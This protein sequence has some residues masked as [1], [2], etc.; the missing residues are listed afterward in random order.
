MNLEDILSFN[1]P[2]N[3]RNLD[4]LIEQI[5]IGSVVPYAGAG[6]SILFDGIYPSWNGFLESTFDMFITEDKKSVFDT[7]D[8]EE[9]AEFLY[10][11]IGKISFADH[12]L[13]TFAEKYIR[14]NVS[15]FVTKPVYLLPIIFN[16]G[17]IMT[18]NYDKV[19]ERVYNIHDEIFSVAHPGHYEVFNRS[20]RDQ[21]LLVYKIHGDI[22]EP[23]TSIILSKE[24]YD[25]AY[26]NEMLIQTL[27]QAFLSKEMLFLGCSLTKDKPIEFLCSI[28]SEGMRNFA[29][30]SCENENK[31]AKRL[32]LEN[33]FFTQA[34]LY[35]EGKHE[36][37]K[38]LLDHIA[39]LVNPAG[40]FKVFNSESGT[41]VEI[42]KISLSKEWFINQN[43]IQIRNL[44]D[45]Y[46]PELN[47][48][49][50]LS[51]V[52]DGLNRSASFFERLS[53][54]TDEFLIKLK[55]LDID[56]IS[57]FVDSICDI[58]SCFSLDQSQVFVDFEIIQK[59]EEIE[60]ILNAQIEDLYKELDYTIDVN[61]RSTLQNNIYEFNQAYNCLDEYITYINS[62][63]ITVLNNPFVLLYGEGG[64]GKSHIIADTVRNREEEGRESLLF[65]GQ[66]FREDSSPLSIMLRELEVEHSSDDFFDILNQRAKKNQSRIVIFIDA[67]NEGNGKAVWKEYL[68]GIVE[69]IKKYDWLGLVVSVRE[70]YMDN[71]FSD[72]QQLY[73]MFVNVKHQGFSTI[74]YKAIK[75]YFEYYNVQFNDI[76]FAEQEFRNPL[77]LRLLCEGFRDD[78]IKLSEISIM[79][80]YK[81]YLD[82]INRKISETCGYSRHFNIVEKVINEMVKFKL[83]SGR[84][85]NLIS[86]ECAYDITIEIERRYNI[87]KSLFD[88]LLSNGVLTQNRR[89]DNLDY[90]YITYERLDDYLYAHLLVDDLEV[91][92]VTDFQEKYQNIVNYEGLLE[93]LAIVMSER[94]E[95]E[96]F[97]VFEGTKRNI[98]KGFC[99]S[100]KW[101]KNSRINEKTMK[102]INDIVLRYQYGFE[103]IMEILLLISTK[104]G[105][106]LNAD[107][108]VDFVL[109]HP[110]PE[111]DARFIP[112]Y[113]KLY[114]EEGSSL[115][116]L[117]DWCYLNSA[118]NNPLDE[119]IRLTSE[120]MALFLISSNRELRDKTTKGLI[121]VLIGR[122]NVLIKVIEKFKDVD[123]PYIL[124]RLFAVAYGCIIAEKDE[125][126][127]IALAQFT[128]DNIF[129]NGNV[130]PNMLLRDYAKSIVEYAIYKVPDII[131]SKT[132]IM[133]PYNSKMPIIPT[134]DDI[135]KYK[136]DY[137]KPDF[138]DYYWSQNSILSS[139]KVEYGRDGS[140]GGYGDFG[141]YTF[142]RYFSHW[143]GLDYHDLKN[144][145]IKKIFDLGYDVEKHGE[146]DRRINSRRFHSG[147][148]ERIGKKY[149]W[150]AFYEL[151]ARV[152]DN[153]KMKYHIDCYGGTEDIFCKGAYEPSLRNIDPTIVSYNYVIKERILHNRLYKVPEINSNE[154]LSEFNDLPSIEMMLDIKYDNRQFA[155]LN[156]SYSWSEDKKLGE[157]KYQNPHKDM[158]V[159]LNAYI[160]KNADYEKTI[161][162]LKDKDFMGR[163]L[164]EPNDNGY[165]FNK[166]YY[167]SEAFEFYCSPYYCG[168]EWVVFDDRGELGL[169]DI[170]VLLPT[171]RYYT[172]RDGDTIDNAGS[173]YW[174][175]PCL[176]LV[177]ELNMKYGRENSVLFG[178]DEKVSC[179]DSAELLNE[180]I[181]F[182]IDKEE[183]RSFLESKG[184]KV[185]W[186][187]LA[188]KRILGDKHHRGTERYRQPH[189]SGVITLDDNSKYQ[190][191]MTKFED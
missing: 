120:V 146:Y 150:I 101:R 43:N 62:E 46:L 186:T 85:N 98:I 140:S 119:T 82:A 24:Q 169:Y 28:S 60:S 48:R 77:F 71:I 148:V 188:E 138:K 1:A 155:L 151:A 31:Q 25:K 4:K 103:S 139:M 83:T 68:G 18:T 167:W 133:P 144:I 164:P 29:I 170:F 41:E 160:I 162:S 5:K 129:S 117:I 96:I 37:L 40:Y 156:G 49:L 30:I 165:L 182:F 15:E 181:G 175:K 12:L 131:I 67:L 64:I 9:K 137:E 34:I 123:D 32:Q 84:A 75:K 125:T 52:F 81:K 53:K 42:E 147:K 121:N 161:E 47:I 168:E 54:K 172:E 74:E 10:D 59:C 107:K 26:S 86:L 152:A 163:W 3:K 6:M 87:H 134:D 143:E 109:N 51:N 154:W 33:E 141:R 56:K 99:D 105:H 110:M 35:P 173:L 108:T 166:E 171:S 7:L 95:L 127:I 128:Y 17:L 184:Y 20:L 38:I 174:Y 11:K 114:Y 100:L 111:R 58:V 130:Y 190:V 63:E 122:I 76:P 116:R 93:A 179:F 65:L 189:V 106:D 104:V 66:V 102:Y 16:K 73:D 124:E 153:Y 14:K 90:V 36:A 132:D 176:E 2:Y 50:E 70:E 97:E 112:L 126:Q 118:G 44:G 136:Y 22:S 178:E 8:F 157:E 79:D 158:W 88:E 61:K 89:Y 78:Y 135:K 177:N 159:Q 45:R 149:Q 191:S 19:I 145:A 57:G 115:N 183:M 92:G 23:Q 39:R 13:E 94:T 69:K 21:S 72:N 27:K 187:L 91:I 180:D 185:F 113:D 55:K 80:V 142:Q